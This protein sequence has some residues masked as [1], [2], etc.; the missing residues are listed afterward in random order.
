MKKLMFAAAVAAGLAAFGDGI[1]SSNT[2]GYNT[3]TIDKQYTILGIPFTGTTGSAMSIQDA[4]P[5][6]A[7]MTKGGATTAADTIQ[8]MDATGSY[9]VYYM[10][11]GKAGKG[12]VTG[13]DGKWVKDGES[14]VSS[15]TM[16]AGTPFW[17]VSKNYSTPYTITVAGQV[18]STSSEQTPLNVTY[19]LLAN[20]Y[21]C[22]L[23]LNDCVPYVEGM[24]K[25]GATTAADTIQIMD[26]AG[27]YD[28]YYMCNGKA[29]K[30]TV[31]GGDGKW[32][33]DGESVV[34]DAV[35]PAGKGGW[36]VR[37][38]DSL[39]NITI[40]NPNATQQ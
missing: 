37:K 19:Q 25:G 26:A 31:T 14:V 16:A 7:G 27:S 1:E 32:V 4:V 30:G 38:S 5:Y 34:T 8:I 22:D 29:G 18:L 3:V 20:P 36:F 9:D 23:P 6:S 13:G 10:C 39:A 15:A 21:P 2:V 24:T 12:T 35:L 11:N 17:F 28:V 40:V 33:K